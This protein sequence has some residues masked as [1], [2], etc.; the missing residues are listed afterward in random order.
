MN[1]IRLG[2]FIA[3]L[4]VAFAVPDVAQKTPLQDVEKGLW[5]FHAC[6]AEIRMIDSPSGGKTPDAV[7]CETYVTG[8]IDGILL[9]AGT[10][11]AFCANEASIGTV[12]RVYVNYMQ[13]HP[14]L[15]DEYR[16]VGLLE[17]I[18]ANY[19]CPAN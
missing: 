12:V 14:K 7:L 15:L 19:P 11:Q 3:M 6:Q 4:V 8:F 10:H 13:Q 9:G 2:L 17:A 16:P 18:T 1:K 5:L